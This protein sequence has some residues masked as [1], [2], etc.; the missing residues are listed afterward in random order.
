M[1]YTIYEGEDIETLSVFFSTGLSAA[2]PIQ[3]YIFFPCNFSNDLSPFL[4]STAFFDLEL[5][6]IFIPVM[7]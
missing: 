3:A 4:L 2:L 5:C 7:W 1:E 6:T